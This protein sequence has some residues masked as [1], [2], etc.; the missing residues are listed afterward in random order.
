MSDP[1]WLLLVY[2]VPSEP[3]RLRAT[4]LIDA[5]RAGNPPTTTTAAGTTTLDTSALDTT[6]TVPTRGY[7][8][9]EFATFRSDHILLSPALHPTRVSYQVIGDDRA[10]ASS[11]H[12]PVLVELDLDRLHQHDGAA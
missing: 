5:A 1:S 4:G 3:S 11:D 10:H 8:H 2:R 12:L 7:P 9:A 6:P